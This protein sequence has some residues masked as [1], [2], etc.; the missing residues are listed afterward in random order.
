MVATGTTAGDDIVE[1]FAAQPVS[2]VVVPP[3]RLASFARVHLNA[4]EVKTVV[5]NFPT[6]NL[7]VVQGDVDANGPL[8]VE[9]GAY[10]LIVG[11]Q[12]ANFSIR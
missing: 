12:T 4:G 3:Q 2:A 7:A 8:T 6:Q 10:Q 5:L 1:A 11:N 9:T